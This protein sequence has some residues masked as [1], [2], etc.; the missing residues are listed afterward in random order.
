MQTLKNKAFHVSIQWNALVRK[1]L[2]L[3]RGGFTFCLFIDFENKKA[4]Y[5]NQFSISEEIPVDFF[6]DFYKVE[7]TLSEIIEARDARYSLGDV[8]VLE[9]TWEEFEKYLREKDESTLIFEK[10]MVFFFKKGRFLTSKP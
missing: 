10:L 4:I 2:A 8:S 9:K 5:D 1:L 3:A 7:K 6:D